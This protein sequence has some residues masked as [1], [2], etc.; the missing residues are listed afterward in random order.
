MSVGT[1]VRLINV[2]YIRVSVEKRNGSIFG[3]EAEVAAG[4]QPFALYCRC[5]NYRKVF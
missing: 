1:L 3:V 2:I 4:R 5:S